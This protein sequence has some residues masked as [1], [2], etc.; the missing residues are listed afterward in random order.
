MSVLIEKKRVARYNMSVG[1]S[2]LYI[3]MEV[4][5]V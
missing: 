1:G 3:V 2:F 4:N 5:D